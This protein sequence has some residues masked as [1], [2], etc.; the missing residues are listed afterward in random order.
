MSLPGLH[1]ETNVPQDE[2]IQ[3]EA[4]EAVPSSPSRVPVSFFDPVGVS[5][6]K[7][8][9]TTRSTRS[10]VNRRE[11][12]QVHRRESSPQPPMPTL[13]KEVGSPTS[14]SVTSVNDDAFDFELTLK[15][16]VRR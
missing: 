15:D 5:E 12:S 2:P 6:L 10:Q 8:T 9:M 16:L 13:P 14:S 7:R 11:S 1:L 3:D 4:H